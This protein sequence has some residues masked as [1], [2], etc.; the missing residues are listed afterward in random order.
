M[1][2]HLMRIIGGTAKGRTIAG[3]RG[4][5]TRPMTDRVREALFSSLGDRVVD[6]QVLDLYAGSGSLGL[7]ALS[8]GARS[9]V[10][11]EKGREAVSVLRRN[12]TAVDLGGDIFAGDVLSYLGRADRPFDL[13]FVDP[14]YDLSLASVG[15]VLA[16]LERRLAPGAMVVL[17]RRAG[18]EPP[19]VPA[20][21]V[22]VDERRYGDSRLWRYLKEEA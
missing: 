17:H 1:A 5:G 2:V 14:P 3:P 12:V 22:P 7:E 9:V 10:F 13:V 19:R 4:P 16:C 15:E 6:A 18:E 11:V 8:R 21:L 20:G